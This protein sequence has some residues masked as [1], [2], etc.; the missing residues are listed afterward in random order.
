MGKSLKSFVATIGARDVLAVAG[1]GLLTAGA[2]M[3]YSPAAWITAGLIL[4]AV[5][6]FG[7]PS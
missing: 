4:L 1:F 6:I 5:A 7:I 3:V 2:G